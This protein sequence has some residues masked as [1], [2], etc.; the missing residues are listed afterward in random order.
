MWIFAL[1][2]LTIAVT[3]GITLDSR[4]RVRRA[5]QD[6]ADD[7]EAVRLRLVDAGELPPDDTGGG[8]Y[9]SR[10]AYTSAAATAVEVVDVAPP[11]DA[12]I[13]ELTVDPTLTAVDVATAVEHVAP[14]VG[15]LASFAA[16]V[17]DT[18]MRTSAQLRELQV[19]EEAAWAEAPAQEE[20]LYYAAFEL[21]WQAMLTDFEVGTRAVRRVTAQH[22]ASVGEHTC[23]LCMVGVQE[24]S[25]EFHQ[26]V[27][28]V[29]AQHTGEIPA[30][31][32]RRILAN[33]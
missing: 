6:E 13:V 9:R 28:R 8:I 5:R 12:R 19:A 10:H 16:T 11:V 22:H 4:Y 15:S 24:I 14:G 1:I 18:R 25:D 2:T 31:T 27:V 20:R 3:G 33:R 29:E 23:T 32:M 26:I 21:R 30:A 17:D 7:L